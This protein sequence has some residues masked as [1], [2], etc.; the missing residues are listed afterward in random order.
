MLSLPCSNKTHSLAVAD[1][2][3]DVYSL[4]LYLGLHV[5]LAH[6][7]LCLEHV[8]LTLSLR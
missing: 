6:P 8:R 5:H 7:Q 3:L 1:E 4:C 2:A